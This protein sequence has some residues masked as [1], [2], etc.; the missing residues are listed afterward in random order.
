MRFLH[1]S[2]VICKEPCSR[3]MSDA[4]AQSVTAVGINADQFSGISTRKGRL[5][6]AME[7]GVPEW[8]HFFQHGH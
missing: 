6:T 1:D 2:T 4:I 5:L 8:V 7:A 3:Q